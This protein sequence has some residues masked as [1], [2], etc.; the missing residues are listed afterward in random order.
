MVS[1]GVRVLDDV[2]SVGL[3]L[4]TTPVSEAATPRDFEAASL[5]IDDCPDGNVICYSSDGS[6]T[7]GQFPTDGSNMGYCYDWGMGCCLPC[8]APPTSG[9]WGASCNAQYSGCNGSCIYEYNA[10]WAC[11]ANNGGGG[12]GVS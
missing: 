12:G 9:D 5:F 2:E 7:I 4:E 11:E 8:Q 10:G 6:E 3:S 1:Y